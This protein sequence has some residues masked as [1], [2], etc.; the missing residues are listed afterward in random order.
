MANAI[1]TSSIITN[2]TLRILHNESAFL[3]NI[4]TEYEDQFAN[5]G[6][7]AG[8]VVNVRQP[9]Q[10]TIRDGATINIQDVNELTV[11]ITMEAEF[12]IDWAFTDYD[13]KLSIDEFSKRYLAPA[14]K[15]LAAELDLRIATRFYRGVAN[16]SGTP[17]TP[18]STAQAVLDAAVLLDNAACPRTDGRMLALTPLSNAKLVGGMSGLFND[19]ATQGKQ[20]KN[21]MMSTNLGMDFIMSQN[22]PT[23]TVGGLGGTPLTNGANQGLINSGSTDNPSAATTSL[24]TDGWTAAVANRLKRGDVF[25]IAGVFAVNP[26]TK[27]STGV[28]R[29]FIATADA[30]S[31]GAGNLTVAIYPAIIAGGAYQNVTARA[32]DNSAITILTGTAST[33]YGQNLMFH[34]D[35]FTLVTADMELPKGMDMAD[36]AVEDGVSIRFIRGYDITNNRRI[37]RFDLLAGYGLLRPEWAVR[38]TQ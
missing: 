24:V 21:G 7:K 16:F 30:A 32:A 25:T 31:D 1:I 11:P 5:K 36:R 29:Q 20:L 38:V 35:A 17:G 37:C 23:H 2:E 34:R 18:I 15:R 4:N 26:E 14:A 27:V 12:G 19:Q 13:L 33:A 22:L 3:G 28:L 8:S 9:V 10:Y 6:M